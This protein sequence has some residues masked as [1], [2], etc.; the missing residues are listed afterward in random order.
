MFNHSND[1]TK[2]LRNAQKDSE[3]FDLI[4][5]DSEQSKPQSVLKNTR[6]YH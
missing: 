5:D 4:G 6:H 1:L 3:K 2:D